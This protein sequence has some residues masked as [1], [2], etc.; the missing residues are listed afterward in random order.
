MTPHPALSLHRILLLLSLVFLSFD[1]PAAANRAVEIRVTRDPSHLVVAWTPRS[2]LPGKFRLFPEYQLEASTNL[3]DWWAVGPSVPQRLGGEPAPIT[4]ILSNAANDRL[5]LRVADRLDLRNNLLFQLIDQEPF[6][7]LRGADLR[8]VTMDG[9]LL[10][11]SFLLDDADFTGASLQR[12]AFGYATCQRANF[13]GANARG[14]QFYGSNL[15]GA[16]FTRADL[17]DAIL[18]AAVVEGIRLEHAN[19]L[20]AMSFDDEAPGIQFHQTI[21]PDGSLRGP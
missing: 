5:F 4:R 18:G 9:S 1:A 13:T 2:A 8:G 17:R 20:N 6:V 16:N 14:G 21:M 10:G 3:V 7:D 11:G 12:V 19:L 15:T